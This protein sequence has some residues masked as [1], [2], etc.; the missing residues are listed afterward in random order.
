MTEYKLLKYLSKP[1]DIP[2]IGERKLTPVIFSDS[3]GRYLER[4][5]ATP[6][7]QQFKWWCE[8]SR[9]ST[10]GLTWLRD[11][12]DEKIGRLHKIHAYIWVGTCDLTVYNRGYIS[13]RS[14]THESIDILLSNLH[15]IVELFQIYPDSKL[16]FLEIPIYSIYEWNNYQKHPDVNQFLAQD[17]LLIDQIHR[18][19][20]QIKDINILLNSRAPSLNADIKHSTGKNSKNHHK[21]ERDQYNWTLYKD[22]IHPKVNLSKVWLR[23]LATQIK[24]DCW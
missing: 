15:K 17:E 22:G 5:V 13:L 19:N 6:F 8:K 16:S 14:D 20:I 7:E 24:G 2:I 21:R 12:L 11:N 10:K 1:F 3:K 18:A 4:S 23:K 9:T